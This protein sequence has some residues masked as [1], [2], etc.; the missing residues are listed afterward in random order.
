[1]LANKFK[2]AT[3]K[4]AFLDVW[5]ELVGRH[6]FCQLKFSVQPEDLAIDIIESC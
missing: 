4:S 3:D 1:L 2:D 5:K 6:A